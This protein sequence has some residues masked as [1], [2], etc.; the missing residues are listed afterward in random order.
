MRRFLILD[1]VLNVVCDLKL[2][3]ENFDVC[4]WEESVFFGFLFD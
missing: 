4:K 3:V 1:N 2:K